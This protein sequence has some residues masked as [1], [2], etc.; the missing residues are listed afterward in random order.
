MADNLP[1]TPT[2][3]PANR[4]VIWLLSIAV[5]LVLV[6]TGGIW[7]LTRSPSSEASGHASRPTPTATPEP[8]RVVYTADWSHGA[9]GWVLPSSVQV[10]TSHL[11]FSGNGNANLTIP[12]Q[13]SAAAYTITMGMEIDAINPLCNGGTITIAG[14]DAGGNSL[15]YAQIDCVGRQFQGCSGGEIAAGTEGGHYPSGIGISD[16]DTGPYVN[17]YKLKVDASGVTFCYAASCETAGYVNAPKPAVKLVLQDAY[18]ELKVT[19]IAV[20]IP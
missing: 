10:K 6:L 8:P 18:L 16:F 1:P 19:S 12:Y 7:A 20:S 11:I 3:P 5:V 9:G 14:Q 4:R 13:P 2:S 17:T 15:Y